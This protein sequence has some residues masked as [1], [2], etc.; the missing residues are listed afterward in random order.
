MTQVV[1]VIEHTPDPEVIRRLE[2]TVEGRLQE[3][4]LRCHIKSTLRDVQRWCGLTRDA[5]AMRQAL[6]Y[7]LQYW[8]V[9]LRGEWWITSE[10]E[11]QPAYH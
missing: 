4:F 1:T 7:T 6:Q 3:A 5:K 9:W 10:V 11:K 8:G 2:P